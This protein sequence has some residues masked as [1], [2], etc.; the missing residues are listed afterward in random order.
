MRIIATIQIALIS[1]FMFADQNLLGPNMT[2]IGSEFGMF[3]EGDVDYYIGGLINLAFWLLGGTISLFIGYFTDIISRRKLFVLIVIIGEIPCLLSGFADTYIEFFIM[4]ALTG[5]GIG[6][7]I[8]ITY[9]LLG[10]YYGPKERIKVVT[11]IGFASGLGV[12]IGQL[13]S[14]ML[15]ETFGWRLPFII[16]ALPN[17]ILAIIFFIT[18]KEPKR[19]NMDDNS[20][21]FQISD[22]KNFR[23]LFKNK[24]NLLVFLQGI[25]GTVP[26][27]VFG[28]FMIDY[29]SKNLGYERDGTATF[30]LTLVGGM[31]ILSSLI[32]GFIGNKLYKKNPKYLPL[33]CGI[34]TILGVIPTLLLINVPKDNE[35]LLFI[36]AAFTGLFIAMTPPNM[37]V[38]LMNVNNPLNRGKVFSLYNFADDLGRGFGPFIIGL[39]L[40]P[41]FGRNIAFNIA[42]IFWVICGCLILMMVK[43]FPNEDNRGIG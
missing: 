5:L 27:S 19:G 22:F 2:Q 14:G 13:A 38:I 21:R 10:D 32:G 42:S 24:T 16:F 28:I 4:R 20:E 31:A 41:T 3:N 15:G 33:F 39:L 9:S 26:W 12:A 7:I 37:K 34:S 25:F 18:T 40:V 29:L 35:I 11:L 36:Y 6:G 1:F 17:F 8:P 43:T 23:S 30:A